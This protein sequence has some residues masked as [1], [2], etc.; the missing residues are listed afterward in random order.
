MWRFDACSWN[1]LQKR[2]LPA[3]SN[4]RVVI[5]DDFEPFC[6]FVRASLR[7]MPELQVICELS[8]G[9]TAVQKAEELNPDVIL[10]DIGLPTLN[11]IEAARQIRKLVPKAQIIFLSQESSNDVVQEA[12]SLGALGY[13]VKALVGSELLPAV[14]AVLEGKQFVSAGVT[15]QDSAA[16]DLPHPSEVRPSD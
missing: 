12:L 2:S 10:L 9:L 1:P 4:I 16:P 14:K 5:V 6:G 15:G 13:V 11:G 3:N 7:K 8:D